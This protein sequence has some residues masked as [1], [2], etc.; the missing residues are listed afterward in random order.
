M[1]REQIT[2]GIIVIVFISILS[3]IWSDQGTIPLLSA[4]I[5]ILMLTNMI[6]A[7]VSIFIQ[8]AVILLYEINVE[9]KS[10]NSF[11]YAFKYL[12]IFGSGL[13]YYV[14]NACNR[15]PFIFNKLFSILFC[16]CLFGNM[17][18]ILMIY[19]GGGS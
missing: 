6:F 14:Q 18:L 7:F 17:V 19:I 4:T 15:L 5:F 9:E 3:W 10:T 12:A 1:K 11:G 2:G 16:F 13:N 8:K